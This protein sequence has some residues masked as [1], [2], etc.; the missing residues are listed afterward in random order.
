MENEVPGVDRPGF[1]ADETVGLIV[2]KETV[3]HAEIR[4]TIEEEGL[5]RGVVGE[6]A[7]SENVVPNDCIKVDRAAT[8]ILRDDAVGHGE[9]VDDRGVENAS[10]VAD[11]AIGEDQTG[12]VGGTADISDGPAG[13]VGEGEINECS[14]VESAGGEVEELDDGWH[15]V[16]GA[17]GEAAGECGGIDGQ[18]LADGQRSESGAQG[19]R[20]VVKSGMEDDGVAAVCGVDGL[21]EGGAEG[22]GVNVIVE[23]D[24]DGEGG[25]VEGVE[26]E[27]EGGE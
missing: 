2:L 1:L 13:G 22:G 17:E 6:G 5:T 11:R 7:T 10:A 27:E 19:D 18:V 4:L 26:G 21:A 14:D 9:L 20:L 23:V 8:L 12:D 3:L 15:G 25:G 24:G 16:P